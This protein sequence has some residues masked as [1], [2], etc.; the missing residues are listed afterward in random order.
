V[1]VSQASSLPCVIALCGADVSH[2]DCVDS[3]LWIHN[4]HAAYSF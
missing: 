3:L 4:S 2:Q 1:D